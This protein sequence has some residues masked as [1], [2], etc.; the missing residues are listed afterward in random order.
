MKLQLMSNMIC[1]MLRLTA[2]RSPYHGRT[3]C[4]ISTDHV[5]SASLITVWFV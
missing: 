4:I 5:S 1:V 3:L 2:R